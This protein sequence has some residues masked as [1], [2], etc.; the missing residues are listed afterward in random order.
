MFDPSA[1]RLQPMRR[2]RGTG[3]KL[4]LI[5]IFPT[6]NKPSSHTGK[7]LKNKAFKNKFSKSLV[8]YG[9]NKELQLYQDFS[10]SFFLDNARYIATGSTR[11]RK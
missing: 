4:H 8:A 11:M 2:R 1:D 3:D 5:T 7:Q 6:E 9:S 10:G